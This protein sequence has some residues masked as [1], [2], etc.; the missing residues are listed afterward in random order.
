MKN[1]KVVLVLTVFLMLSTSTVFAAANITIYDNRVSGNLGTWSNQGNTP[2]EDQEVEPGMLQAQEWDLEGFFLNG[3]ILSMIGG[4][5]FKNGYGGMGSGD[6]FIDYTGDAKYGDDG[7]SLRNG[8]D[9][10]IDLVFG[11]HG[12]P[13]RY[14][15]YEI[16]GQG[17]LVDVLSYN[18]DKSSPW[19]YNPGQQ[20]SIA[21][22][23]FSYLTGNAALTNFSGG[24]HNFGG[25]THYG[26]TGIDLSFLPAGQLF[27]SH[28]TMECGNDNLMG[29]GTTQVPEPATLMLLCLGLGWV[30]LAG[31]KPNK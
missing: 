26:I 19:S 28:F 9:Y 5:D 2:G 15:V 6:I 23:A 12:N 7:S 16:T 14:N 31:R 8:Y 29:S 4:F 11:S 13:D 3:N 18:R 1:L 10:A 30:S 25:N 22:G 21:S 17:T 24:T 27:T 20:T